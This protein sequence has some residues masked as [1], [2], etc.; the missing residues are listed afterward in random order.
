M[1]RG[2]SRQKK[3]QK[4][5][6][7]VQQMQKEANE[8]ISDPEGAFQKLAK[9]LL[10]QLQSA[11]YEKNKL[12]ALVCAL[13]EATNGTA[14]IKRGSIDQFQK[15]R[16][17]ILSETS[18]TDDGT[19]PDVEITFTYKAEYVE[20]PPIDQP[21]VTPE[22]ASVTVEKPEP[23]GNLSA[24]GMVAGAEDAAAIDAEFA[25]MATDTAYQEEAKT[26]VEGF[27]GVEAPHNEETQ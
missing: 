16:L 23:I 19:N 20:Q 13:L 4:F 11:N 10:A 3:M 18:P 9:P 15:H 24:D 12:S 1:G 2:F 5:A 26:V 7:Q 25:P 6:L 8:L 21:P 22:V 14:T 27:D 17:S